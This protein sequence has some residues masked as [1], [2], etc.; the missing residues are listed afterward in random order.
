MEKNF[1]WIHWFQWIHGIWKNHWSKNWAYFK[2]PLCDLCLPC[3]V[4]ASWSLTQEVAGSSPFNDKYFCY[5]ICWIQWKHLGKTPLSTLCNYET[6]ISNEV[7]SWHVVNSRLYLP[8]KWKEKKP[9]KSTALFPVLQS[10]I[11]NILFSASTFRSVSF[12]AGEEF[13]FTTWAWVQ[14]HRWNGNR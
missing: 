1:H 10:L 9:L 14:G 7:N 4:V 8:G 3:A 12:P 5:W 13:E 2:D 6:K 11:P